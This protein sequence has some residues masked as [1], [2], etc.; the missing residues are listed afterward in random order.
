[1]KIKV[2][3]LRDPENI[4]ALAP[5]R[6]DYAGFIFYEKSP[7]FVGELDPGALDSLPPNTRRVG[8]FVNAPEEYILRMAERYGLDLLQ[9]HGNES[10]EQC[11]RLRRT[12]GIIKAIAIEKPEDLAAADSYQACCDY[13]LFDTKTA[14]YGGSGKAFDHGI[15]SGYTGEIPYFLSGGIGPGYEEYLVNLNLPRCIAVD[16]NSRF[17]TEP[18]IKNTDELKRFIENIA[19]RSKAN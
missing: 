16:L 7:R 1:M 8:V 6:P 18:G 19:G 12:Y 17:E 14:A 9:L 13:L 11:S 2:C 10:P 15:L 3:G 5:L 4:A